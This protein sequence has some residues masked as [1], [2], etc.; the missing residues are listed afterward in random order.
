MK[1]PRPRF[2]TLAAYT[3]FR[4]KVVHVE[5]KGPKL[6]AAETHQLQKIIKLETWNEHSFSFS[7]HSHKIFV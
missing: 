2:S 6:T 4:V 3:I 5:M 7:K 1:T